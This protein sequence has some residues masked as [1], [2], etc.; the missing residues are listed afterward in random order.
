VPFLH[1][2]RDTVIRDQARM[3]LYA[4]PLKDKFS[5]RDTEHSRNAIMT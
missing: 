1:H 5:R 4:E 3:M 2:A